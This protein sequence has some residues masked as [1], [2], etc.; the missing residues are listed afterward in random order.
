MIKDVIDQII[1]QKI[2]SQIF[3]IQHC[4]FTGSG[5]SYL[6]AEYARDG[7]LEEDGE[8]PHQEGEDGRQQEAPPFSL[9]TPD[10]DHYL[11]SIVGMLILQ[12]LTFKINYWYPN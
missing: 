2:F 7:A 5:K 9:L 8:D 6:S 10:I 12:S 3:S 4:G 1:H 11:A